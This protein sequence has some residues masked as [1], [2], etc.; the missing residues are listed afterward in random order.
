[1]KLPWARAATPEGVAELSTRKPSRVSCAR[2]S[3]KIS[4]GE[5][6]DHDAEVAPWCL[7]VLRSADPLSPL[8]PYF[9][10]GD[11]SSST[12]F[13]R[14]NEI[15][16]R[17]IK[18]AAFCN[19]RRLNYRGKE[20]PVGLVNVVFAISADHRPSVIRVNGSPATNLL[21]VFAFKRQLP[22]YLPFSGHEN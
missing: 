3:S 22:A 6:E 18:A 14:A 13:T 8:P 11:S 9:R 15:R 12:T 17:F 16:S 7:V 5:R 20:T 2:V 1:M 4:K 21:R 10:R 19:C